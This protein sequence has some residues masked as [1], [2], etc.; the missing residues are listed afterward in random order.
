[1]KFLWSEGNK[2]RNLPRILICFVEPGPDVQK[3][4]LLLINKLDLPLFVSL[5]VS[6]RSFSGRILASK[7]QQD[8]SSCQKIEVGDAPSYTEPTKK[9]GIKRK[10]N[11]MQTY[12][13]TR[14]GVSN[15]L[16][17]GRE[18][19]RKYSRTS[20]NGHLSSSATIFRPGRRPIHLLVLKPRYSGHLS[21]TA[22]TSKMCPQP[23]K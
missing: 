13:Q 4:T 1:M 20:T 19:A 17:C 12:E 9:L 6:S 14:D 15:G 2:C 8:H 22:T 23:S 10:I 18:S 7:S 21:T 3:V 5:E 11:L 16:T